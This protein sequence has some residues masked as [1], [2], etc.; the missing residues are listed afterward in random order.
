MI[1]R[2]MQQILKKYASQFQV[3]S[4]MG[5]RQS[6]KTTLA[7]LTFPDYAY[8]SLEEEEVARDALNDPR[9]FL[10]KYT[11]K[12]G[13]IFDEIHNAPVLLS[14]MQTYVDTHKK[15]GQFIITGSHNI[16]LNQA[17]TQ[18]LAGR[19]AILT[20]L[21]LSIKEL[22][23]AN[24][25]LNDVEDVMEKGCYPRLYDEK[26]TI[27]A[28]LRGYVKTYI[29]R[30]VRQLTNVGN[31][32][33]FQ[34]FM[35]LCA[36]RTGQLL[37]V[38]TL[39]CD[40]SIDVKTANSWLSILEMSYIIFFLQPYHK[41][42]RKRI[43]KSPKLYFYDTGLVCSLL[44]IQSSEELFS[45][46]LRGGIFESFAISEIIKNKY[47]QDLDPNIYFWQDQH[48]NEVDC[49]LKKST[50][51]IP[52][53]IKSGRTINPSFFD[54]LK[55]WYE[56]AGESSAHGYLIYAGNEDQDRSAAQVISWQNVDEIA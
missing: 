42:F 5:P 33:K 45:H 16:L 21:P 55:Y 9:G 51:L 48:G 34:N 37:N 39:A 11:K 28:W 13:V 50:K 40:C 8:V 14:Y 7:K 25:L 36:G 44:G 26:L 49:I 29:E 18:T 17:V 6:G 12:G 27:Q 4:I 19:I 43:T 23:K 30:D 56:L 22:K 53:E 54:G 2:D 31:V 38:S 46:Y 20:L 52:I 15:P 32:R 47:N 41:H 35:K 24:L 10:Y 1:K 3:I